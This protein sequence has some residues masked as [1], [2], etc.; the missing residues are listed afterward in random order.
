MTGTIMVFILAAAGLL[1]DLIP[2]PAW[3]GQVKVPF[4]GA[5]VFYYA[6]MHSRPVLLWSAVIAGILQDSLSLV[7]IGY[8]SLAFLLLGLIIFRWRGVMF[9]YSVV[10]ASLVGGIGSALMIVILHVM[11]ELGLETARGSAGW[12]FLRIGGAF[13][14][15]AVVTPLVWKTVYRLDELVGNLELQES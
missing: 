7:P 11:L 1:Q 10:T 2:A 14:L 4:L 6:V 3:L 9:R 15:G 12:V 5:V 8:S 13:L